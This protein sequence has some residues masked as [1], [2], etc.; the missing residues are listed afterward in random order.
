MAI[1]QDKP[2]NAKLPA[3]TKSA[4][5]AF[6]MQFEPSGTEGRI[7]DFAARKYAKEQRKA[8]RGPNLFALIYAVYGEILFT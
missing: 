1:D 8:E 2:S 3:S 7:S 4:L 5:D 6:E